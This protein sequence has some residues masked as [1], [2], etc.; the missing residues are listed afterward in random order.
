MRLGC[1][2]FDYAQGA[3]LLALRDP[4]WFVFFV[5]TGSVSEVEPSFFFGEFA[6]SIYFF[7][8][9]FHERIFLYFAMQ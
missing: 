6:F 9:S 8:F 7:Y 2:P 3:W 4:E 5:C 1:G